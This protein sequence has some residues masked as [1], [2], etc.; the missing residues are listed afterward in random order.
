MD[1]SSRGGRT[2]KKAILYLVLMAGVVALYG[3]AYAASPV[4]SNVTAQQR[5]GTTGAG[6]IVDITYDVQDADSDSADITIEVSNDGGTTFDVPAT[7][8]T[9][10]VGRVEAGTGKAV[11]WQAG[12]DVPGEYWDNCQ[13]KVTAEDIPSGA[14]GEIVVNLPGGATMTMVWIEPRTFTMGSPD[15]EP[16][17]DSS[18]GPQHEVVITQGFYL[19]KFELTQG[20]WEAVMETT[21][22]AG[23]DYEE[24]VEEA[25]NN[26]AVYISWE[27][28]QAFIDS[29]N[30]AEGADVYRL[31]TEAEW[32]Y[33]CRA[34]T[35]TRWSFGDYEG[36]LLQYAWYRANAFGVWEMYAHEVGTKLPNPWGLHDMH[37][38]VCEWCQDWLDGDYYSVSPSVDPTGPSTGVVHMSRVLRGGDLASNAP[39]VRSASRGGSLPGFRDYFIGAR[40]LRQGP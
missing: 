12:V 25:P 23:V 2:M 38:N 10:D 40:L 22:W 26:P 30:T 5:D 9:G 19:G 34:G 11:E 35:T 27:D 33:A 16:D 18:E 1:I 8:F 39:I 24:Y 37:G 4:V 17:R 20:Q 15:T 6:T 3:A 7:T 28:M 31:P 32:E 21:P 29:L 36:D 14:A 13:A